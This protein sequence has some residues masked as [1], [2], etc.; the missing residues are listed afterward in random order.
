[1]MFN[2]FTGL[3]FENIHIDFIFIP[4]YFTDFYNSVCFIYCN[5]IYFIFSVPVP[6]ISDYIVLS[7]FHVSLAEV[8]FQTEP[9]VSVIVVENLVLDILHILNFDCTP[10]FVNEAEPKVQKIVSNIISYFSSKYAG[11]KTIDLTSQK[12]KRIA[13]KFTPFFLINKDLKI[14]ITIF[15][16]QISNSRCPKMLNSYTLCIILYIKSLKPKALVACNT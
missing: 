4:L 3:P 5:Q 7:R 12:I 13:N 16:I 2:D 8:S 11:E 15:R 10:V 9:G 14:S 1:M 6:I